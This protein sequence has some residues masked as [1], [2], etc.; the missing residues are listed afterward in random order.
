MKGKKVRYTLWNI[1]IPIAIE[2][3][4][5]MLFG[6]VDTF[7]LSKYCDN[8]VAA[9]G[10]ATQI[11]D[12]MYL[13]FLVITWG[14]SILLV[15]AISKDDLNGKY[16]IVFNGALLSFFAGIG[17]STIIILF[18]KSFIDF[19]GVDSDFKNLVNNYLLIMGSGQVF[20][21]FLSFFS[22]VYRIYGKALYSTCITIICNLINVIGDIFVLNGFIHVMDV[23]RDV[24]LTT[25]VS[26][27][28]GV[29]IF[30]YL[31]KKENKKGYSYKFQ[32]NIVFEIMKLGIPSAGESASYTFSQMIV[33]III[34]MLGPH[35]LAAKIY[36]TKFSVLL[37]L[38]P[39]AI[40]SATNILVGIE[41]GK[42]NKEGVQKEVW[43]CVKNGCLAILIT[44]VLFIMWG[45]SLLQFFTRQEVI[46]ELSCFVLQMEAMTMFFKNINLIIGNAL[47][48]IK[49]VN[50]P[51]IIS[52]ASMWIIGVGLTWV[53]G[54]KFK[55]G[56]YGIMGT[57]MLEEAIR[58]LFL[59][60][61]WN[62][63]IKTIL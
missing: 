8:A 27:I 58:A 36:G 50:Y 25:V 28:L 20:T 55:L 45:K 22:M 52:I 43:S 3:F 47:R 6:V 60:A 63:Q 4:F 41:I 32:K 17:V 33:T 42:E 61:R 31:Y 54:I 56:L 30:S 62:K 1:A 40:A 44:D 46:L 51:M 39:S 14:T 15:Q 9:V 59:I 23:V 38:I 10:Y 26:E 34:T 2:S 48:A 53:M 18:R 21:A 35:V 19:F 24:A 57:F 12:I 13:V 11:L 5:S 16:S 37:V 7:V 49:D 29:I